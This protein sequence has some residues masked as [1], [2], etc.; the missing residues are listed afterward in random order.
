MRTLFFLFFAL[1][2]LSGAFAAD[3]LN[4]PNFVVIMGEAQGWA[5]A[6]VQMDDA[7]PG[8][9]S[10]F[11]RTPSLEKLAAGGMRFANFYAASPRC[12]PT[13]AAFFTGRS[14]A[15]LHMTFVGEGM[16]GKESGFSQTGSKLVPAPASQ[17]LP[18]VETTIAEL[19]KREGYAT[20]HFGK[21]HIGRVNPARHGFEEND[22]PNNNGGPENAENPNPK[23]AFATAELGMDFMARQAKAGKPFYLQVSHYAGRG[24][25]DARPETYADVRQRATSDRDQ[26]LAGSAAVAQDMDATIG[27]L[28]T[29][30]DALGLADRTYV[31]YT[32]DHGAQGRNANGPL[33]N[34]KGTVWEGGIRVPL[35]VRG[36]G[37]KAG[38]CTHVRASTVDLFPTIAAMARV[39]EPLPRNLEGGSLAAVLGSAPGATV[40]RAREEFVV[41]FPHYDKDEQGPASALLL[42]NDKLIR[43]YEKDAPLLFDLSKDLGE[44]HDLAKDR[45]KEAAELDRRLSE[46]LTAVGAQMPTPNPKFDPA[47]PQ[48]FQERRGGQGGKG[49]KKGAAE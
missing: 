24:G 44:Q 43:P 15:A 40:K 1:T 48:P 3:A 17:E 16:G 2:A 41:H 7:V 12:T 27:M 10:P 49:G 34:G 19:L 42:G 32:A 31:I 36:P 26:R 21:W 4:R 23:Q 22:G 47:N 46:Y 45:A 28:M 29:R 37:I 25:T 11:A 35:I 6:S 8:S 30:L 33:A 9:K 14:P 38:T 5:S 13:R 20:A 39:K 18:E